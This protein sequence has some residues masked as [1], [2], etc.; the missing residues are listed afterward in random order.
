LDRVL[1][2]LGSFAAKQEADLSVKVS[3]RL[4]AVHVDLGS[5]VQAGDLLAEIEP[6]DYQLDLLQAEAALAQA[7]ALL[8]LPLAGDNDEIDLDQTTSV[9]EAK[10]VYD[11]A[12]ANRQRAHRLQADGILSSSEFDAVEAAYQVALNRYEASI[13]EVRQRQASV[14]QR[15]VGVE[16]A[17]QQLADASLR[18]PFSGAVQRRY[19]NPGQYVKTGD[20]V[21]SLVQVNPLRLRAEVPEKDSMRLRVGQPVSFRVTGTDEARVAVVTR[22]S[23][24]LERGNRMLVVEADVE[25]DGALHPGSFAEA[26]IVVA[27]DPSAIM[28]PSGA[29]RTFAGLEK[30]FVVEA[31]KAVEREVSTGQRDGNRVE[32]TRGIKEGDLVILN[33]GRLRNGDPVTTSGET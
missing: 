31:G 2:V 11:Q 20:P 1:T 29:I 32:V 6:R 26:R 28:V 7:R 16:I 4:K 22:L 27:R 12:V 10:A 24:A 14:A 5:E 19:V 25:N 3:G 30:V 9:R 33:P 8:G 23:P 13:E 21:V 18:A 17:R 15:R